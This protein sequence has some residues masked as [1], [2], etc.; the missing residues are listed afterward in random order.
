MR[1]SPDRGFADGSGSMPVD[2]DLSIQDR[3]SAGF[4]QRTRRRERRRALLKQA[5]LADGAVVYELGS[6]WGSL[7]IALARAFPTAEI[8][9]IEIS[10]LPYWVS[11]F[12]TRKMPNVLLRRCD[13]FDCDLSDAHAVTCYLMTKSMPRIAEL[14]DRTLAPGTLVVSLCFWFRGRRIAASSESGGPLHAVA[15]YY[16]PPTKHRALLTEFLFPVL[17]HRDI[18]GG[19]TKAVGIGAKRTSRTI[20]EYVSWLPSLNAAIVPR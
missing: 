7:V 12:R 19:Y 1:P 10:S 14:L 13:F 2:T 18:C 17:A 9:G 4:V 15:L 16:W 8:R 11:R 20:Y 5:G 6:G 3:C